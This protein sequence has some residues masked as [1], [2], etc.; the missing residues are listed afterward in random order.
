[1]YNEARYQGYIHYFNRRHT[2]TIKPGREKVL[3][4]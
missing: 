2:Q 3:T 4:L 1:M